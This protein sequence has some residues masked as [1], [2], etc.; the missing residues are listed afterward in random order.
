VSADGRLAATAGFGGT[1]R[2]F[3]VATGELVHT[4]RGHTDWV[5][6]LQFAAQGETARSG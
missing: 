2:V 6:S 4:L 5:S 1:V 3:D